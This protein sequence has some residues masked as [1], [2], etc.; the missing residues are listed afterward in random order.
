[1]PYDLHEPPTSKSCGRCFRFFHGPASHLLV[2]PNHLT[3]ITD[4][5]TERAHRN[6]LD[7]PQA[8]Q[9]YLVNA[10]AAP[11]APV[12]RRSKASEQSGPLGGG[13]LRGSTWLRCQAR[14]KTSTL[15]FLLFFS[16]L[17]LDAEVK[18]PTISQDKEGQFHSKGCERSIC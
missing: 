16:I 15:F 13:G 7:R 12:P 10:S 14:A 4:K 9:S 11:E 8:L 3:L 17:S 18:R 6:R 2:R 5:L 1:M